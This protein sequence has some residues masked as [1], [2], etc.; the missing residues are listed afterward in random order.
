MGKA[1]KIRLAVF[2]SIMLVLPTIISVLPMTATEVSAATKGV[3]LSWEWQYYNTDNEPI[4]VENGQKFYIG[5]YV[6]V[7]DYSSPGV[8]GVAS[9]QKATYSSSNQS[10]AT[11]KSNGYLTAKKEGLTTITVKCKGKKLTTKL[12]VVPAGTF[13]KSKAITGLKKQAE[14][15][16]KKI[17]SKIT[18][19][20]GFSLYKAESDYI[21]YANKVSDT[22]VS[23]GMLKEET[24]D[25]HSFT[26]A[27]GRTYTYTSKYIAPKNKLVV[28]Q[29]GRYLCLS[30]MFFAYGRVNS[31]TSTLPAKMMKVKSISA[32]TSNITVKIKQKLTENQ[33]LGARLYGGSNWNGK[34]K[35][36][37]TAYDSEAIY[38]ANTKEYLGFVKV[39][40]KKGSNTLK[41]TP[42][43]YEYNNGKGS[44][45]KIKLTKG[46][47]YQLGS[48][49]TWGKG[50]IFNVK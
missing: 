45:V 32:T 23:F 1:M 19:E 15:L 18:T 14:K 11:V 46:K 36:K 12:E 27:D 30:K 20:N 39:E 33:I 6:S 3:S 38:D 44:Y 16:A 43:K 24:T 7:C 37:K 22:L 31:P 8:Y 4:Q 25:T 28:P 49:G 41:L 17:P 21:S 26:D 13:G 29:A 42:M 47:S 34:L 5:D 50:T 2:L 48:K 40:M 35:D 10:V 9:M